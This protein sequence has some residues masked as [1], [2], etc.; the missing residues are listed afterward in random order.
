MKLVAKKVRLCQKIQNA[1]SCSSS[2]Q[3]STRVSRHAWSH[4][5]L[6]ANEYLGVGVSKAA[7]EPKFHLESLC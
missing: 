6:M 5:H 7:Q 1:E 2:S 4:A 3:P